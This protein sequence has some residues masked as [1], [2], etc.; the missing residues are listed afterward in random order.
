MFER[1]VRDGVVLRQL[2]EADVAAFA[3][4]VRENRT[5]L[6]EWLPDLALVD[7]PEAARTFLEHELGAFTPGGGCS[8]GL[9]VVGKLAGVVGLGPVNAENRSAMIGY[10]IAA[11]YQGQGLITDGVRVMLDYAFGELGVN[12]IEITCP[13]DHPRSRAIPERLGFTQEGIRRQTVWVH[14]QPH[15]EVIYGLL[16]PEWNPRADQGAYS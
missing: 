1:T 3:N 16:A 5:H 2:T 8:V 14:D 11:A 4:H 6:A 9:W 10:W 7:T 13:H 15:D 12:R